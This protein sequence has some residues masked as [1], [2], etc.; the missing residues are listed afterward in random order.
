M[1]ARPLAPAAG[2]TRPSCYFTGNDVLPG[3]TP[4][5]KTSLSP[6]AATFFNIKSVWPANDSHSISMQNDLIF[7]IPDF[8]IILPS[9]IFELRYF[10]QNRTR[11]LLDEY[12]KQGLKLF[13][14]TCSRGGSVGSPISISNRIFWWWHVVCLFPGCVELA[15]LGLDDISFSQGCTMYNTHSLRIV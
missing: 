3:A 9:Y 15:L 8:K 4:P 7:L 1:S 14:G 12:T 6:S 11:P 2:S 5:H 13:P 10:S